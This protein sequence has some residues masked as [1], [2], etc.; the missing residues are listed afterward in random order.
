VAVEVV[1]GSGSA[2][3]RLAADGKECAALLPGDKVT[4]ERYPRPFRLIRVSERS[5]YTVLREK[6]GLQ[7]LEGCEG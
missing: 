4:V 5:F 6:I 2:A 7:G 3:F 1:P